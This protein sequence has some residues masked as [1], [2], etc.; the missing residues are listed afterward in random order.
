MS[1]EVFG[2]IS[3]KLCSVCGCREGYCLDMLKVGYIARPHTCP[4]VEWRY[5]KAV[6]KKPS[7]GGESV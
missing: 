5:G 1:F 6:P 3:A 4:Y 7:T 2:E